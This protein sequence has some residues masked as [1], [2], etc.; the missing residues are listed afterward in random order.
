MQQKLGGQGFHVLAIHSTRGDVNLDDYLKR[1]P[2]PWQ[3][4]RDENSVLEQRFHVPNWPSLYLF[5]RN[6]KLQAAKVHRLNL[7]S[8]VKKLLDRN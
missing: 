2:K 4:I 1:K 6:G 3:N 8:S 7:E 5:D